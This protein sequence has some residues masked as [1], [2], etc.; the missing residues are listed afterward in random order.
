LLHLQR[1]QLI[2]AIVRNKLS[3]SA[4]LCISMTVD[5]SEKAFTQ[6]QKAPKVLRLSLTRKKIFGK[7]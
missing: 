6:A 5:G 3:G 4:E 7:I 2:V 1:L